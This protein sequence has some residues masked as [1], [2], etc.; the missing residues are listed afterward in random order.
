M[1]RTAAIRHAEL[2]RLLADISWNAFAAA[3]NAANEGK[4]AP[5]PTLP[6]EDS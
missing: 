2:R 4:V 6:L 1:Q 3:G 5:F